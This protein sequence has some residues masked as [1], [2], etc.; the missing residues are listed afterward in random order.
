M[1]PVLLEKAFT[2]DINCEDVMADKGWRQ[3][4]NP[5][6]KRKQ[7]VIPLKSKIVSALRDVLVAN[8][9]LDTKEE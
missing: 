7:K 6:K 4:F 8:S 1:E 5:D 3:I 9:L 2:V